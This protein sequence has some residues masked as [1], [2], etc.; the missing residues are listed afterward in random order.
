[1][2]TDI[3]NLTMEENLSLFGGE[4]RVYYKYINGKRVPFYYNA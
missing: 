1:M 3:R 2:R 4:R